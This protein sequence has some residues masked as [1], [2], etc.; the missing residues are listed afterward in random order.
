[1]NN[2]M[3]LFIFHHNCMRSNEEDRGL[4]L[5]DPLKPEHQR[6]VNMMSLS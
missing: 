2:W 3:K 4:S 1:M 6:L 5:G